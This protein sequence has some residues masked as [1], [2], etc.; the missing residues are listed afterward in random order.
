M[1]NNIIIK[2]ELNIA[3]EKMIN[4]LMINKENVHSGLE[5]GLKTAIEN[6]DFE[7]EVEKY[8]VDKI[9]GIIRETVLGSKVE[10]YLRKRIEKVVDEL[11]EREIEHLKRQ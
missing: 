11:V 8:A 4:Q 1:E 3:A 7:K 10:S 6:F 5:A 2:L 9:R